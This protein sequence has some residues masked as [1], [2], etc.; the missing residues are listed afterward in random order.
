MLG[1][2]TSYIIYHYHL[3]PQLVVKTKYIDILI[4]YLLTYKQKS[5]IQ[6]A[7]YRPY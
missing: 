5:Y 1:S 7:N 6:F 4:C 2:K 3:C